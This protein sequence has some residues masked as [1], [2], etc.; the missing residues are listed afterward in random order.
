M[1]NFYRASALGLCA[2]VATLQIPKNPLIRAVEP[3]PGLCSIPLVT[4]WVR[5]APDPRIKIV[6]P[7]PVTS[8]PQVQLPAPPCR[9]WNR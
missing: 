9:D 6:P 5:P 2:A 3:A 8:M 1:H 7:A 4:F